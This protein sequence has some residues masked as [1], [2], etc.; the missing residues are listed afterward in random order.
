M[1]QPENKQK[2]IRIK[3][4][5]D[6]LMFGRA[7]AFTETTSLLRGREFPACRKVADWH[8]IGET[9]AAVSDSG[10]PLDALTTQNFVLPSSR[11]FGSKLKYDDP[12]HYEPRRVRQEPAVPPWA[13]PRSRD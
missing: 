4:A 5:D 1:D 2:A 11:L 12:Q 7:A 13:A 6:H 8:S 10:N 9:V 3:S